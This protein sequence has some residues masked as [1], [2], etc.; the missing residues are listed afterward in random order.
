M[1]RANRFFQIILAICLIGGVSVLVYAKSFSG[2]FLFDDFHNITGNKNMQISR[3]SWA[4]LKQAATGEPLPYRWFPKV[5]FALNYYFAD[6]KP[7]DYHAAVRASIGPPTGEPEVWG[8]HLVNLMVH[9]A[10]G[11]CLY[12]LFYTTLALPGTAANSVKFNHEAALLAAL[13]WA[14]HPVQTNAVNYIVQRMTSM[15][16]LF[17]IVSLLFYVLGRRVGQTVFRRVI[18]FGVSFLFGVL[19]LFSKEN[20]AMLPVM[21]VAFEMYFLGGLRFSFRNKKVLVWSGVSILLVFAIGWL[22]MGSNPFTSILNG[23]GA[24]DFTLAERL[25]TQPRIVLH[26]LTLV[27]FPLPARL[28]LAYD[29]PFS[30]SL[31]VPPQTLFAIGGIALLVILMLYLYRS[32]RLLSF[33]IFWFL[34]NLLI[35]SSIIPLELIFEHRVYLPSMFLFLAIAVWIY[36][37]ASQK[38]VLARTG[39]IVLIAVLMVF[40]WQRNITWSSSENLWRDVAKKAPSLTRGHMGLYMAYK[41]QGRNDEAK[42]ALQKAVEVGPDQFRP[43]FN[44]ANLYKDEKNYKD[45]LQVLNDMLKREKL[46]TAPVY[47]LRALIYMD[48]KN[49]NEAIENARRATTIDPKHFEA[50]MILGEAYF[51]KSFFK[52]AKESY[53]KAREIDA[54]SFAVQNNLGITNYNLGNYDQAI[55]NLKQALILS[56][57]NAGV[58]YSLGMVYGAK[59]MVKEMQEQFAIS[60]KLQGK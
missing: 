26:Y 51:R 53:E 60:K 46:R 18:F 49:Y 33:S 35:E 43:A 56:P 55:A 14:V 39:L 29:Y 54:R 41:T 34:G 23:Y 30:L 47:T 32:S 48:L 20:G 57:N 59:G 3:L 36:R 19:S 38:T 50:R 16:A 11:I 25:L 15:G 27:I 52:K 2:P 4:N 42:Q 17:F 44:L 6:K 12:F 58:H 8:F 31:L 28:N 24:R 40:T 10:T 9:I 5:S 22:Y 45:A 21:I 37:V 7:V 13:L 1:T